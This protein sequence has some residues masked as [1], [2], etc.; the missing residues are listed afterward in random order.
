MASDQTATKSDTE[1]ELA[2]SG[3]IATFVDN[4]MSPIPSGSTVRVTQ[5]TATL[6]VDGKLEFMM[7]TDDYLTPQY[8]N[9]VPCPDVTPTVDGDNSTFEFTISNVC[10]GLALPYEAT[11]GTVTGVTVAYYAV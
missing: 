10:Y 3:N 2:I 4:T 11:N 6:G 1:G 8:S 9:A 5:P 7:I